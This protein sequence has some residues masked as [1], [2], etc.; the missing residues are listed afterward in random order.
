M[1]L[2]R[3]RLDRWSL[4]L[5]V[6][7]CLDV[8]AVCNAPHFSVSTDPL[9]WPSRASVCEPFWCHLFA[10]HDLFLCSKLYAVTSK[11]HLMFEMLWKCQHSSTILIMIPNCPHRLTRLT[12]TLRCSRF[13]A[14]RLVVLWCGHIRLALCYLLSSEDP[15]ECALCTV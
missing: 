13:N 3:H 2:L 1:H 10:L 11:W 14:S 15:P 9:T 4:P 7:T 5:L 8:S 12:S 6:Y